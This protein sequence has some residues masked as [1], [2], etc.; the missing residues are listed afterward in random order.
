MGEAVLNLI[1]NE[2]LR[3]QMVTP[4]IQLVQLAIALECQEAAVDQ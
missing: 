2:P 3:R 4:V 1:F